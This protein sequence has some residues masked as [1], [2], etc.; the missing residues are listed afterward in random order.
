MSLSGLSASRNRSWAMMMLATS[1][2]IGAPRNTIRSMRSREK[3]SYVRSPRLEEP[4][5]G[6]LLGDGALELGQA[7]GLL[8]VAVELPG[9]NAAGGCQLAHPLVQLG[10]GGPEPVG[11]DHRVEHQ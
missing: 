8:Q 2:L 6:L 5:E 11:F 4:A 3:M 9:G 7:V 10:L 1:S